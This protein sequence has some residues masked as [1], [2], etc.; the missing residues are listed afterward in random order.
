[1]L[2]NFNKMLHTAYKA[3]YAVG[4]FNV[5]NYETMKGAVQAAA[6]S[7]RPVILAFGAGYLSHMSF[8]SAVSM[9]RAL[10]EE[11]N[12]ELCLHLDHC[13]ELNKVFEA[14]GAGF[15]SVMYDG[16]LLPFKENMQNTKLVCKVAHVY[17]V[18]VEAELGR[19][20]ASENSFEGNAGG[21]EIFTSAR[22]AGEFTAESGC[23]ALAVSIGAVHGTYDGEPDIRI[24]ILKEINAAAG[25][26]LVLHGGS[27][28]SEPTIRECIKNG[29]SKININTEISANAV[30]RTKALLGAEK[31]PHLAAIA[32][33]QAG[34]IR[35]TVGK[36]INLF[37]PS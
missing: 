1:M 6:H 26:P 15:N 19:M 27:G 12:V 28:I 21:R 25:I 16:S 24:D 17:D 14:I 32:E 7:G 35:E 33:T 13:T 37:M 22:E 2:R 36:Y 4:A 9:A 10:D 18:S 30:E 20:S 11:N 34:C 5:Y 8:A 3:G 29:I 31:L 23:D